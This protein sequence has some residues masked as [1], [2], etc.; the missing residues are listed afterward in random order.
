MGTGRLIQQ[1]LGV[2]SVS[3]K[4]TTHL[5]LSRDSSVSIATGYKLDG[6]GSIPRRGKFFSFP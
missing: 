1:I 3:I 4:V 2:P 6:R 5:K